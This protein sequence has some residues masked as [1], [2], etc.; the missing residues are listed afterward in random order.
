MTADSH[1]THHETIGSIV[2]HVGV[3]TTTIRAVASVALVI[4]MQGLYVGQV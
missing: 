4:F 2:E 1:L 3:E